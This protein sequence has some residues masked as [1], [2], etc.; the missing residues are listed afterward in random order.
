MTEIYFRS[1]LD[2][3]DY[4]KLLHEMHLHHVQ[5]AVS[6]SVDTIIMPCVSDITNFMQISDHIMLSH[7]TSL[8]MSIFLPRLSSDSL[9]LPPC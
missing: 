5:C 8:N 2:N 6:C 4:K 1:L 7:M 9:T 3:K